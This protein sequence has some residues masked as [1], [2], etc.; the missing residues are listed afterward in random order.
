M[1]HAI[2]WRSDEDHTEGKGGD[3]LLELKAGV[4]RDQGIVVA[5]HE[6]QKVA[7]LDARPPTANDGL[8][9]VAV[10]LSSEV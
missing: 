6:S 2:G 3:V 5:A 8:D 7:V 4:H 9:V 1:H 10:E